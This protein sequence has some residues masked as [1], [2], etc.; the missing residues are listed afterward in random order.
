MKISK[1]C[2]VSQFNSLMTGENASNWKALIAVLQE[3]NTA[4]TT[5]LT[6][7]DNLIGLFQSVTF[8]TQSNYL[9]GAFNPIVIPWPYAS[10]KVPQSCTIAQVINPSNQQDRLLSAVTC[11]SWSYNSG[12]QTITV[13]YV[14]G[15][16]NSNKYTVVFKVE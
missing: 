10:K 12:N 14:T 11:Q 4:L 8:T 6:F 5:N 7:G 13:P 16:N 3:H 2:N 1:P 9:G 15:L